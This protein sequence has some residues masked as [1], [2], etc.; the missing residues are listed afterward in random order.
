ME[1]FRIGG[2]YRVQ[3][4]I[5]QSGT[6]VLWS[7]TDERSGL[8]IMVRLLERGLDDPRR[9][10]HF[11]RSALATA[12]LSHPCISP[13]LDEG[14]DAHGPFIVTAWSDGT[15]LSAWRG[16]PLPWGFV[17]P[18]MVRLCDAMACIHAHDL[19]QLGLTPRDIRVVH[20]PEGP[21][22]RISGIGCA[23]IDDGWSD[24]P[25]GARATLKYL[26]TLRYL[27]PEAVEAAP[28]RV[29][30]R[31]DLYGLGLLL[32]EL[33]TGDIPHGHETGVALM[34]RRAAGPPPPLPMQIGGPHHEP[35]AIL[36]RRLLDV[37][38][39]ERPRSATH[40]GRTMMA[41]ETPP[42]WIEPPPVEPVAHPSTD[43]RLARAAGFPL[44]ALAP[45]P[46]A[47]RDAVLRG[48]WK[49]MSDTVG[50]QGV[51]LVVLEGEDGT[52]KTHLVETIAELAAR[53]V[54]VRRWGVSYRPGDPP[55]A[56]PIGALEVLLRAA[57]ADAVGVTE[58]AAALPLLVGVEPDGVEAVLT[59]LLRP[60]PG[61]YA[62]PH[63][64]FSTGGVDEMGGRGPAGAVFFELLRRAARRE[65]ML[66]HLV[67]L[68]HAT[69]AEA[70]AMLTHLL[71]DATLPVCVV[72]TLR[73]DTPTAVALRRA[74]ARRTEC[75]WFKLYPLDR[76]EISRYLRA[77]LDM[78]DEQALSLAG[79]LA[80]RP[81]MMSPL[82]DWLLAGRLAAG[83]DGNHV[84]P[85]TVLPESLDELLAHQLRELMGDGADALVPDVVAG[86]AFARVPLTPRVIDA[87]RADDP[88]RPYDRALAAAERARLMIHHP[89]AGWRFADS[90][91]AAR[92]TARHGSRAPSWHR[93]WSSA[94]GRLEQGA[95]G[96]YGVER[97][98]HAEAI[99]DR[100]S[101]LQALLDAATE[102]L[103][104]A[105]VTIARGLFA[106]Q[107]AASIA[108]LLGRH[109]EA[110]QADRLRAELLWRAGHHAEARGALDRAEGR[111]RN[112]Q[113]PV[114]SGFC[115]LARGW[116]YV[117]ER[118]FEKA[119]S[120]FG[121]A[122]RQFRDAGYGGG[123]GW[124]DLGEA[125]VYS[126]LGRHDDAQKLGV[127]AE[128][129]FSRL[130]AVQGV[131]AA[132]L[133]RAAF[134]GRA[135]HFDEA[136]ARYSTLQEAA[137]R[138]GWLL[139]TVT[140]RLRRA[141]VAVVRGRAEMAEGLLREAET[142]ASALH[143]TRLL[144]WIAAVRPAVLA[145]VGDAAAAQEALLQA[146]M[147]IARL[148]PSAW[149]LNDAGV[150]HTED[151]TL[152]AAL[153]RWGQRLRAPDE[154]ARTPAGGLPVT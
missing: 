99:G 40:A 115:A 114:E 7:G 49:A 50:G 46:S 117:E 120:A 97:A 86:L 130:G 15:P 141:R 124:V 109:A 44:S 39:V 26:G 3:A 8:P 22:P 83:P 4:R 95:R 121:F 137:D 90:A 77:R 10:A 81:T 6:G 118:R 85:G 153:R 105:P 136:E 21:E 52:G 112:V 89:L 51:R 119:R 76:D 54:A 65:P 152:A 18:L 16:R 123:Q 102:A 110:A 59:G 128:T 91:I 28:W 29:G 80:E 144:T 132:Q 68:H 146:R 116:F 73:P 150:A 108:E 47:G 107:R 37:D 5:G 60:D 67:D 27:A 104:P 138:H 35:L 34:L 66:L 38:P 98:A 140:L 154:P 84:V 143:L 62:R 139:E 56:G 20:G 53:H 126:L 131:T 148:R 32:W 61:P 14:H 45:G 33:L 36:T 103:G 96:R 101:A 78:A 24:R 58:R 1:S 134:A 125:Q 79:Y 122:G 63:D 57:A 93:R 23:R 31:S 74:F 41:L 82:A 71:D 87:L 133:W 88:Q 25:A 100:V 94:L 2:R 48:L 42:V 43:P 72:V 151:P 127:R 64:T 145:A 113:A 129:S 149:A 11:R 69:S 17:R 92:L 111:L 13:V 30:P 135:G 9:V 19:L 106:A 55:G 142:R 75:A 12:R 70:E 147:P